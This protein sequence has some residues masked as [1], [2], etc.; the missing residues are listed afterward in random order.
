MTH[1]KFPPSI[2][3]DLFNYL[4]GCG[5]VSTGQSV[6]DL[7]VRSVIKECNLHPLNTTSL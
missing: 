2:Q 1:F 6:I 3:G 4:K 5:I 7:M